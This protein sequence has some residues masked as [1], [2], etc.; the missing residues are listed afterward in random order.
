MSVQCSETNNG[1][2]SDEHKSRIVAATVTVET[3]DREN[4]RGFL[5]AG[6]YLLTAAHCVDFDLEGGL[7]LGDYHL[8]FVETVSGKRFRVSPVMI[9]P[10]SDLAVL[11][12]P[13]D[14][15]FGK[16]CQEFQEFIDNTSPID[17]E[18]QNPLTDDKL[19]IFTHFNTWIHGKA[20]MS[21]VI[22]DPLSVFV[23]M[24]EPVIGGT[25]GSAV[26][27][28]S[29][30]A[31][32]VVSVFSYPEDDS[33]GGS[34]GPQPLIHRRLVKFLYDSIYSSQFSREC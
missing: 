24:A 10:V 7:A 29:G 1:M 31:V 15:E 19:S 9:D 32:A 4:G 25:S 3:A 33:P 26:L 12:F 28:Q 23:Q 21:D 5:V 8:Q 30:K 17:I 2:L 14:Q 34:D 22:S 18:F 6:G 27:N 11:G 16:D 13:D 20:W